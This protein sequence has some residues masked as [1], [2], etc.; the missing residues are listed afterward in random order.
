[1]GSGAGTAWGPGSYAA[2]H[3]AAFGNNADA[4]GTGSLAVGEN[5]YAAGPGDLAI[6]TGAHVGADNSTAVGTGATI[7]ATSANSVALGA[8]ASVG[9]NAPNATALGF[10]ATIDAGAS[11]SVALGANSVASAPNTVSVGAPGSERRITNVA[12]GVDGTDA[13]NVN[14]LNAA[15]ASNN[16]SLAQIDHHVQVAYSGVAMGM[17]MSAAPL[18]LSQGEQGI[19]GGVATFGG[20]TAFGFHYQ[21]QPTGKVNVGVAVGVSDTGTV[22]ASAGIGVKF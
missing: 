2:A 5:S 12:A 8:G 11:N 6:G 4:N 20:R 9:A 19:S 7:A 10:G 18:T 1:V 14:Q 13:V 15:V 17:A 3:G 21:G 16:A 22:G